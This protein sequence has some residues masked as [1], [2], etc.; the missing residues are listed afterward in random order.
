MRQIIIASVMFVMLVLT[1]AVAVGQT[2]ESAAE[3]FRS[4]V[5]PAGP[6]A[7]HW[8]KRGASK[9]RPLIF[10]GGLMFPGSTWKNIYEHFEADHPVYVVTLAG[11]AG[12]PPTTPPF[13]ARTIQDLVRLIEDERMAK[14]VLL[15]HQTSAHIVFRVAAQ[16]PELLGGVGG[17]PFLSARLPAE[18]RETAARRIVEKFQSELEEFWNAHFR[19]IVTMSCSDPKDIDRLTEEAVKT[20]RASFIGYYAESLADQ[21]EPFFEKITC[22]VLLMAAALHPSQSQDEQV[23]SMRRSE[24]V[25][26]IETELRDLHPGLRRCQVEIIRE[27]RPLVMYDQPERTCRAIRGFLRKLEKPDARWDT[28]VRK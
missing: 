9:G 5:L 17:V 20:D 3:S 23:R 10:V 13:M 22:P 14:P 8:E 11:S 15:G 4:D 2:T 18:W 26:W 21:I 6:P 1:G 16:Y 19:S 12:T 25:R 28:T 24:Y 7:I 27:S